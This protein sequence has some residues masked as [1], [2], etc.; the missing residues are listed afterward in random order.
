VIYWQW[1]TRKG[2]V[3]KEI[4]RFSIVLLR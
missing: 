3:I 2:C 1:M 4:F